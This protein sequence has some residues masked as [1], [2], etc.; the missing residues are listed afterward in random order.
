ML[1]RSLI[2]A[3]IVCVAANAEGDADFCP[4]TLIDTPMSIKIEGDFINIQQNQVHMNV[5]WR[6]HVDALDT[7]DISI[8]NQEPFY[9]ITAGDYRYTYAPGSKAKRQLASH[10]LRENLGSTPLR[11]DDLE[12]L[13]NGRFKCDTEPTELIPRYSATWGSIKTSSGPEPT[14]ATMYSKRENKAFK[15]REWKQFGS[16]TLPTDIEISSKNF[17]GTIKII[18][19]E[20]IE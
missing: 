6:H 18:S 11:L 16:E 8:S 12:L 9:F 2:F 1:K 4:R 17:S 15:I 13:A 20:P 3:A 10:H 5:E 14:T 7:F 19:A